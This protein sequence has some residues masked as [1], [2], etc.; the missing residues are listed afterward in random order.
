MIYA[1]HRELLTTR[2]CVQC[3]RLHPHITPEIL[4]TPLHELVLCIKLLNLGDPET[5]LNQAIEVPSA[6][7]VRDAIVLLHG[8]RVWLVC[9]MFSSLLATVSWSEMEALDENDQL[10]PLGMILANMPIEPRVGRMIVLGCLF[11]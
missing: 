1:S 2:R 4:R 8:K 7:S 10:T 11:E 6:E 5:F 9:L 3:L